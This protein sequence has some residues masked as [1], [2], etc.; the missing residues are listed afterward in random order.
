MILSEMLTSLRIELQDAGEPQLWEDD[1]LI[2]AIEK[3]VSLMSRLLPKRSIVET[4]LVRAFTGETLTI[5]ANTGT[6]L[7]KPIKVGSVAITG[8]TLDTDYRINY[9]TGI[10]TEIGSNLP[11]TDYTVGYE[12]DLQMLDI[13]SLLSDYI[14]IERI[15]YPAGNSPPSLVT[16][17]VFG[18]F[19]V[20]RGNV[21]LTENDHLRIIYLGRWT[22]P[23]LD[24]EGDYPSNLNDAVIIGSS[25]QAL[26]NKAEKYTQLSASTVTDILTLLEEIGDLTLVAPA[27]SPPSAPEISALTPPSA[28]S[29][30]E[31][32][33]PTVPT[34]GGLT[35]PTAPTFDELTPPNAPSLDE[36][37]PPSLYT[38]VKPG[39]PNLPEVPTAPSL[40]EA[41]TLAAL[42]PAP[43]APSLPEAPTPPTPPTLSFTDFD[44]AITSIGTEIAAAKVFLNLGKAKINVATRGSNVG[45]TYGYYGN[46]VMGAVPSRVNEAL[47][48]LREIEE[49]ITLYAS[50]VAAF[51][52]EVN[53]YANEISGTVGIYREEVNGYTSK[54]NSEVGAYRE[55]VNAYTSEV[56]GEISLYREKISA[57]ANEVSGLISNYR[58]EIN[59]ETLGINNLLASVGRYNA[60]IGEQN[61]KISK[62][63][64]E[65]REYQAEINEQSLKLGKFSEEVRGYLAEISE[66]NLEVALFGEEVR[67]Y[68]TEVSE[69]SLEVNIFSE[70]VRNYQAEISEESLKVNLFSEEIRK[71]QVEVAEYQAEVAA[72][73]A[74][75]G[76]IINRA[77][78]STVQIGNYLDIAGRYLAS[79]QSKINEMLIMLGLKPEF[80]T[81][82]ASSEQRS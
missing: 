80:Q 32:T 56:V 19:L 3:S 34:L 21:S 11:D 46:V 60:E 70:E 45:E 40:P 47:A 50:K 51:G 12:L 27:L 24:T 81:Q 49:D 59:A 82:K 43:T 52:S 37:T 53:A 65:I 1:E 14:K 67:K 41:P 22:I 64:E 36:L 9:I 48:R 68:Q 61:L 5:A 57:Y 6:L 38:V 75:T 42:P 69:Q 30:G 25:G 33:P 10:V 72:Y 73:T 39:A 44:A 55:K 58:E 26:I 66:Q 20:F 76:A 4:T 16:A 18:D 79:G 63:G 77:A 15:E 2:R 8:K 7:Y 74:N 28:P 35:P 62:F 78:Q 31:L 29:L 71:Y 17:D 23:S 54:V 13:S